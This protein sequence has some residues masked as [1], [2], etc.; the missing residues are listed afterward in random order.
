MPTILR[1]CAVVLILQHL[2]VKAQQ[3]NGNAVLPSKVLLGSCTQYTEGKCSEERVNITV[4][5]G[6]HMHAVHI[7]V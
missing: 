2:I 1:G 7:T 6:G 3:V 4:P 5:V